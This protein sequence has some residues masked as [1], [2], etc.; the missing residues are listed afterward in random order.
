LWSTATRSRSKFSRLETDKTWALE[1]VD[2]EG[3]SHFCDKQFKSDNDARNTA[4]QAL[5]AE[6]AVALKRGDKIIPFRRP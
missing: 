1:V 5:E 4:L 6:G 3:T 2:S